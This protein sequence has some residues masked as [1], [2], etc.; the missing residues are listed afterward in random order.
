[1][2]AWQKFGFKVSKLATVYVKGLLWFAL[3][4]IQQYFMKRKQREFTFVTKNEIFHRNILWIFALN[5]T[6][7]W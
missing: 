3:S 5:L 7:I 4:Q 2:H 1:M 6:I